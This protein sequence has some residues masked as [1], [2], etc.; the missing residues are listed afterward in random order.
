MGAVV[1]FPIEELVGSLDKAEAALINRSSEI[2]EVIGA[3]VLS[4]V[5]LSYDMKSQGGVGLDG[6]QWAPNSPGTRKRKE[7]KARSGGVVAIGIDTGLQRSSGNPGHENNVFHVSADSI[8]VGFGMHY[9]AHFDAK[10]T[11]IPNELPE[12]WIEEVE[13]AVVET[14]EFIVRQEVEGLE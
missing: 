2:L 1:F 12:S 9:S 13:T 7:R 3:S 5:L 14:T 8:T 6:I 4:N 11:L 10:R